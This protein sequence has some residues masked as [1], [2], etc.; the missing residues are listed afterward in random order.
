MVYRSSYR[1]R[2]CFIFQE[3]KGNSSIIWLI[4]FADQVILLIG[5]QGLHLKNLILDKERFHTI[6]YILEASAFSTNN[7]LECK[8]VECMLDKVIYFIDYFCSPMIQIFC[9]DSHL[10]YM[11][12][13]FALV[14]ASN[15]Q[16]LHYCS[17][18]D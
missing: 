15:V 17:E 1:W 13:A 9:F 2:F 10:P 4:S 3:C 16:V 5:S 11:W 18:W 14:L 7:S 12:F 6:K 8:D